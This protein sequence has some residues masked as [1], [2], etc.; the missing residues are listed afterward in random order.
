MREFPHTRL[1]IIGVPAVYQLFERLPESRRLFLPAADYEDF[2]YLLGQIDVLLAP[3]RN[4]PYNRTVSDR[5]LMEA[6]VR[7]IPW[8]ASPLPGAVEWGAG[9]LIANDQDEWYVQLR[10]L[11]LDENLRTV[12]GRKGRWKAEQREMHKLAKDWIDLITKVI[13]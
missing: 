2:P 12:L 11:I 8:I 4:N 5:Q 9:G 1:V 10:Q 13:A 7:S 6:G 3:L